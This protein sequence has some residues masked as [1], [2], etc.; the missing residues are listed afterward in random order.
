LRRA[1]ATFRKTRNGVA[2]MQNQNQAPEVSGAAHDATP[3][4][5]P[6]APSFQIV[7][8]SPGEIVE[9]PTVGLDGLPTGRVYLFGVLSL[10][11]RAAYNRD[12]VARG[13]IPPAPATINAVLRQGIRKVAGADESEWLA[14]LDELE[15]FNAETMA[16]ERAADKPEDAK[17]RA[18]AAKDLSAQYQAIYAAVRRDYPRLA[19]IDG[20]LAF[21]T[22]IANLVCVQH[23]LK[24]WRGD[25]LPA[26]VKTPAGLASEESL[27]AIPDI[28]YPQVLGFSHDA[29]RMTHAKVKNC[30]PPS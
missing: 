14:V 16:A 29:R 21:A 12:L 8:R 2:I 10:S 28:D 20:D 11:A 9:L 4:A 23:V 6:P 26:F 7:A 1:P 22:Q 30:A 19:A 17:E 27:M 3:A 25:L 15:A 5:D 18:A 13:G 24:G